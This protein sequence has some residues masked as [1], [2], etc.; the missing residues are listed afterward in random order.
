MSEKIMR[1]EIRKTVFDQYILGIPAYKD[2]GESIYFTGTNKA[3]NDKRR[4]LDN[5]AT[6]PGVRWS[7]HYAKELTDETS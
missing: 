3:A 7:I 1:Y 4:E 6:E 5:A 2:A